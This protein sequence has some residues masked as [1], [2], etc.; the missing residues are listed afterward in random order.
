MLLGFGGIVEGR[1][2]IL[3]LGAICFAAVAS[4]AQRR[5]SVPAP[6]DLSLSVRLI[7]YLVKRHGTA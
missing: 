1:A 6:C 2:T 5:A 4:V 3:A 7:S